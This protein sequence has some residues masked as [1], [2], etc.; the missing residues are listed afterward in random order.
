MNIQDFI[1]HIK[2]RSLGLVIIE[3]NVDLYE[4]SIGEYLTAC[5]KTRLDNDIIEKIIPNGNVFIIYAK[6]NMKGG[7][8]YE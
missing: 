7:D 6:Y 1:S 5:V 4:G 8:S 2:H 3:D